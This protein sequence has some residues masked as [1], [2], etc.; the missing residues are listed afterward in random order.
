MI[1]TFKCI[2]VSAARQP[3]DRLSEGDLEQAEG[4]EEEAEG[5]L[6]GGAGPGHGR[7][8]Q[9]VVPAPHQVTITNIRNVQI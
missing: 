8:H 9:G 4:F 2:L 6:R 5:L 3:G 7:P 1:I